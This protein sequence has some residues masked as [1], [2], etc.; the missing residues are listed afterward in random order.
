M[1]EKEK[2]KY[3]KI[4]SKSK[5]FVFLILYFA[6]YPFCKLFYGKKVNWLICERD[7]EAQDNGYIFLKYIKENHPEINPIYLVK[8]GTPGYDN[9]SKVGQVVQFGSL[10]HFL[11]AIGCPVKIS[12][13]LFGY[14]PWVQ[15]KTYYRRNKTHDVHV[16]LQ[17]G[18]T[19]NLHEGLF[20]TTCRSLKLFVCGTKPEYDAI[21]NTFNYGNNVPQYT[22]FARYDNLLDYSLKN[23]LL[24]MPTW[25]ADL[26]GLSDNQFLASDF[27]LKWTELL[28]DKQLISYCKSNDLIIKFYLHHSFK[29]Y[30]HLFKSNGVV[31][32]I[33]YGDETVQSLLKES[34]LL[35]TDFSSVYFDFAF[36][37]KP[38]IFFQFD[39][40]TFYDEHYAKGYFD[41]RRDGFGDVC[42]TVSE[43]L[44]SAKIIFKNEFA[45]EKK[46]L[47]RIDSTF[48][49]RDN[50]N[51]K[52]IFDAIIGIRK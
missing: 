45:V 15:L 50:K 25:R 2:S 13:Q 29:N 12:T 48:L 46:Y 43:V 8:K 22:G 33:N 5:Y 27:Y 34:K 20:G 31:K 24:F 40:S 35:V 42:N 44:D 38:I 47:D 21:F 49:Y 51:C 18:V 17:H 7:D 41:Y 19:K 9:A 4:Q 23:Q 52:R 32:I 3:L 26:V 10:K 11:L 6:I 1:G 16:F 36:M 30:S 39:E 37:K 14:A 28:S